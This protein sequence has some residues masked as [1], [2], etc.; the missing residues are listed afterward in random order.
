MIAAPS[1]I[2][3]RGIELGEKTGVQ[4]VMYGPGTRTIMRPLA[5][6]YRTY[7][8]M[9]RHPTLTIAG[10]VAIAP[11]VASEWSV[12]EK[13]APDG[14]RDLIESLYLPVRSLIVQSAMEGQIKFGWSP[15]ELVW[16]VNKDGK[17]VVAKHKPLLQ[18]RT[19][20]NI[21]TATGAFDGYKQD[22]LEI[23]IPYAFNISFRGEGTNHYG[24]PLLEH[25]RNAFNDWND[26]NA[27]AKRYDK[28]I[29]GSHWVVY[30]PWGKTTIDG[31][32]LDNDVVA[33]S[34]LG[35]IESAGSM[36]IPRYVT[37]E[38]VGSVMD[39][40]LLEKMGWKIELLSDTTAR[41]FSFV[42]RLVYLDKQMVRALIVPERA[43]LEGV[44][45]IKADAGKHSDL[46]LTVRELEHEH[47][48]RLVNWH[49]VN[50][51]LVYNYGPNAENTVWLKPVPL[52]DAKRKFYEDVYTAVLKHAMGFP[53]ESERID[54]SALR[55]RAGI[56][57]LSEEDAAEAA[58]ERLKL[59]QML[60]DPASD[61]NALAATARRVFN[62]VYV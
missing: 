44:F 42:P 5:A 48:T 28:K 57:E 60:A 29:A 13:D 32:L 25:A 36:A 6:Q 33:N 52:V 16:D 21:N 51:T 39:I 11:V 2:T 10:H 54:W 55:Q 18:D 23:E 7:R 56:P 4:S 61:D 47:I 3:S 41:Q 31:Q 15:F 38:D 50:R 9:W 14:A 27:G 58:R 53:Q 30:Y 49:S 24:E 8:L 12:E 19:Q 46:A 62:M 35:T 45:G 37:I 17:L 43:V 59:R 40:E 1:K 34:L 22:Q 26:C 20:I